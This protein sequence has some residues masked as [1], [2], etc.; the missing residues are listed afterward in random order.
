MA[1]PKD[2]YYLEPGYAPDVPDPTG[3]WREP[4]LAEIVRQEAIG[5]VLPPVNL[6][7]P[8]ISGTAQVGQT[9][10]RVAG[11]WQNSPT[12]FTFQWSAN[13]VAISGATATTYVPVVADIGKTITV[14]TTATNAGGSAS[15]TSAPT[16]AVI[17]AAAAAITGIVANRGAISARNT[18]ATTSGSN[19]GQCLSQH[20]LT[21]PARYLRVWYENIISNN[22]LI[23]S[24]GLPTLTIASGVRIRIQTGV[25]VLN[26]KASFVPDTDGVTATTSRDLVL[27]SG[28][29][30]SVVI[31]LGQE[32]AAGTSILDQRWPRYASTPAFYPETDTQAAG[33]QE[34]AQ[35]AATIADLTLGDTQ[36][37]SVSK[38]SGYGILVPRLIQ[39]LQLSSKPKSF[40]LCG[41][42]ISSAGS[43]ASASTTVGQGHA[44]WAQMALGNN[45]GWANVGCTG[46]SLA[47]TLSTPNRYLS[48]ITRMLDKGFTHALVAWGPNDIA[49]NRSPN[50]FMADL[51]TLD[52]TFTNNGIKMVPTTI[53]PRPATS[54]ASQSTN[55]LDSGYAAAN[56]GKPAWQAVN[57][58]N[59][60][61]RSTYS[62]RFVDAHLAVA[63]P[64]DPTRWRTDLATQ[65]S[66][67]FIHPNQFFH[68]LIRDGAIPVLQ[69]A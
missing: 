45:Y 26:I 66:G 32:Y 49:G 53:L 47:N 55:N 52:T 5:G 19:Q 24:S 3:R 4:G 10:S 43:G 36:W 21:A 59:T 60:A 39:G 14:T 54:N 22:A 57:E 13:G 28:E 69:S 44:G 34:S 31:D 48:S 42:S 8:T 58:I 63:D 1:D 11:T 37:S 15:A 64:A 40:L 23:V 12:S 56:G 9:L 27:A 61:I 18:L 50:A 41:D 20:T 67:D 29:M 33:F 30:K 25:T 7:P 68:N 6:T 38:F 62:N 35:W 16:S 17:A 2:G 46:L 51:A 65:P